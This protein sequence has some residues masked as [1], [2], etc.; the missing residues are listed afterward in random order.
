MIETELGKLPPLNMLSPIAVAI[1]IIRSVIFHRDSGS[2]VRASWINSNVEDKDLRM[3]AAS[4]W[5][6]GRTRIDF[7]T[8]GLMG[9]HV[10]NQKRCICERLNL[11]N[12]AGI[13]LLLAKSLVFLK[14]D[15]TQL[16][17]GTN[18]CGSNHA[19]QTSIKTIWA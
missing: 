2:I 12:T 8:V 3:V 15:K 5:H 19:F 18:R 4:N 13:L 10:R 14:R 17:A 11:R 16:I 1:H 7:L 6:D 9:I